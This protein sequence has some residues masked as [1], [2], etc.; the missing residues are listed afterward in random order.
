MTGTGMTLKTDGTNGF[1]NL[2]IAGTITLSSNISVDNDFLVVGSGTF[3]K[4]AYT[5]TLGGV[6]YQR[7]WGLPDMAMTGVTDCIY[8]IRDSPLLYTSI[9]NFTKGF[10]FNSDKQTLKT[11][12]TLSLTNLLCLPRT[13][14]HFEVVS[15]TLTANAD[16]HCRHLTVDAGATFVQSSGKYMS[17]IETLNI[18]GTLTKNSPK[19]WIFGRRAFPINHVENGPINLID[20]T[21]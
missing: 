15:G 7:L 11:K 3:T 13:G 17:V 4:G 18:G 5:I 19:L 21:F 8:E 6:A 14:T 2:R 9:T 12:G 10:W 1:Y 16:F 20:I